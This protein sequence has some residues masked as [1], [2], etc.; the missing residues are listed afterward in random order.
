MFANKTSAEHGKY[1]MFIAKTSNIFH[2][3][4]QKHDPKAVCRFL[5]RTSALILCFV[6]NYGKYMHNYST[7][8]SVWPNFVSEHLMFFPMF[9]HQTFVN[10][11]SAILINHIFSCIPAEKSSH[12]VIDYS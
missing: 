6:K 4:V 2:C 5:Q 9:C 1:Y 7:M 11:W 3:L 8:F 12:T 10:A